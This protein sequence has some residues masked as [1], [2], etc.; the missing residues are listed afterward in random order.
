MDTIFALATA[1][2]RSGVAVIR[3]SGPKSRSV[4]VA[5]CGMDLKNRHATFCAVKDLQG[6]VI[7][8][9]VC[10]F[11]DGPNS[12]TGEDVLE[13]QVHG[14]IAVVDRLLAVLGN[15]D[16]CRVA[17]AG[18]F[19]RR[20]LS[21]GKMDLIEVEGLSDLIEAETELQ[22]LQARRS[23]SGDFRALV[24][25]LRDHIVR[26]AALLE[27]S[28]DFA[29]ED[30]P[31]DVSGEVID[32]LNSVLSDLAEQQTGFQAAERLRE[33]FEIAIVGEPNVGKSTL[34]N[35]LAGR[36][37]AITSSMAGTTRDVIE[38]R[39]DLE[40]IPVTLL[41]TAGLRTTED[42]VES[43]GVEIALRRAK[44]A[45]L[46][47]TLI[48]SDGSLPI[49]IQRGDIVRQTKSDLGGT[50]NGIS[51]K[52]GAGIDQLIEDMV[53]ELRGRVA[54]AGL[55]N[56]RRH[57]DAISKADN[58]LR[59]GREFVA[60]GQEKYDVAAE[61]IRQAAY[62]LD[63]LVGRVDVEH[64]LDVVFRNFCIGK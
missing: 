40:G 43:I 35:R 55:A 38:V 64:V 25:R 39:M 57:F 30:V 18:E 33:G 24:D 37:A 9:G 56:R 17:E 16:N 62:D 48:N 21:N 46:R 63:V 42:P 27:A 1:P 15:L 7:D 53:E 23:T 44:E 41:D 11:F 4:A 14:S 12:F 47:L 29:D 26:A 45:D 28:I 52:T 61:E 22:R 5:V 59:K 34:L 10:I 50:V 31:E 36:D 60:R 20:A 8:D 51:A 54:F 19:T 3:V 13:L 58:C 6:E 32:L 2:G 49:D